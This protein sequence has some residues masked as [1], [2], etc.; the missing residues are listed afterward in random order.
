MSMEDVAKQFG[1]ELTCHRRFQQWPTQ[2]C[3]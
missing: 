2:Y 1:S 3:C